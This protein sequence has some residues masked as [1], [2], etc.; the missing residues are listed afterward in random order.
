MYPGPDCVAF[1]PD[2]RHLACTYPDGTLV[3]YDLTTAHG[4]GAKQVLELPGFENVTC[5]SFNRDG[6]RLVCGLRDGSV[7]IRAI[8][9]P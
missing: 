8:R 3:L 4:E 7:E 2:A 6:S 5:L 9:I 1:L